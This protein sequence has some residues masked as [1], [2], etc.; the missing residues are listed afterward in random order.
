M[1]EACEDRTVPTPV[2]T[3]EVISHFNESG[4]TGQVRFTRD[5]TTG[6]LAV[7][8]SVGGTATAGT[9]HTLMFS[10]VFFMPG[11]ATADLWIGA[12][13]DS[14]SEPTETVIVTVTSGT[15]YTIGSSASATVNLYDDD[16]QYVSVAKVNDA[17]EGGAS[18]TVRFTRIGDLSS[19]LTANFTVGGTATSGTD[20]TSIGTTVTFSANSATADK[21]V[22]PL[23][24]NLIETTDETVVVTATSGSGYTVQSPTAATVTIED[25][26][27]TVELAHLTDGVEGVSNGSVRF[28]RSG[29]DLTAALT[30]EYLASGT[31]TSGTDYTALSGTLTFAANS[32]TADLTV[33]V[34]NDSDTEYDEGVVIWTDTADGTT[35]VPGAVY[36][37]LVL[38]ADT[39]TPLV[40]VEA[41]ADGLEGVYDGQL[42]FTRKGD[43]R[44]A[45]T[46]DIAVSGTATSGTD[47]TAIGT[48][49]TFAA[50]AADA[51]VDVEALTDGSYDPD[52]TVIVTIQTGTGYTRDTVYAATLSIE[53]AIALVNVAKIEDAWEDGRDGR[54]LFTRTGDL[55]ATLTVNYT[56]GGTATSGT[57]FISVGTSVTFAAGEAEAV[58]DVEP[59]ADATSD[60][61]E[62][63][64]VTISTS[65]AYQ[66]GTSNVAALMIVDDDSQLVTVTKIAD[67]F[68]GGANGTLRFTRTGD[69][70]ASLTV[71]YTVT[72]TA[73]GGTD[74]TALSGS[75]SFAANVTSADV[76]VALL[77]D[78]SAESTET[79][80]V[81]VTSGSAYGADPHA[82]D[83][84][85]V[86]DDDTNTGVI[87]GSVWFDADADGI[88]DSG[89]DEAEGYSVTLRDENGGYIADTLTNSSGVY[90]FPGLPEG[91][92]FV[93][94]R[95]QMGWNTTAPDQG[96]NDSID[97]DVNDNG[98]S[99][100]ISL[101]SG[102]M[103]KTNVGARLMTIAAPDVADE[104][105]IITTV[106]NAV[107]GANGDLKVAKW[108]GS[109]GGAWASV[110]QP[111]PG[112][113]TVPKLPGVNANGADFIDLDDDRFN[114][115]VKDAGAWIANTPF[116]EVTLKTLHADGLTT[117][118]D[119]TTISLTRMTV[120]GW[121]GWY[122][123]DS[124][125]LVSTEA[126]DKH[127]D[128]N[129]R[130]DD[131]GPVW[132]AGFNKKA[133]HVFEVSDRTHRISIGGKVS[134]VYA[135]QPAVTATVPIEKTIKLHITILRNKSLVTGGTPLIDPAQVNYDVAIMREI[136]AQAGIRVLMVDDNGATIDAVGGAQVKDPPADPNLNLLNGILDEFTQLSKDLIFGEKIIMTAEEV[137]L[138]GHAPYR[139][140]TVGGKD[141]IEVYYVKTLSNRSDGEAFTASLV[142]D[143]KYK[144]SLILNAIHG[145]TT[146]A[147]E[148]MHVLID[149]GSHPGGKTPTAVQRTNL[150]VDGDFT[151]E[152]NYL[153]ID[154]RRLTPAQS[155]ALR[156]TVAE[157]V[158]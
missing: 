50:G 8:F 27:A 77:T 124:Q 24:D 52:E 131:A 4:S 125:I 144:H 135:G 106:N 128:A 154:S 105:V 147:H 72:G 99:N 97:S 83:V 57:D 41:T 30:I 122:W 78:T 51:V 95:P 33:T 66:V 104:T 23:A 43:L 101:L 112:A 75:V 116:I 86:I 56:V 54:L 151:I 98:W 44:S 32:A 14:T 113:P 84:V 64:S 107:L 158:E 69:T 42:W 94:I 138:L 16:A 10:G 36:E 19:R 118:D 127:R 79:V 15:G 152:K 13:Q 49:V 96:G 67:A 12:Y 7:N 130:A 22:A 11:M 133:G 142:P 31:A 40:T 87:G 26:P 18:G 38:I 6:S 48:T 74:Y 46:I 20:Y 132:W 126:D 34:L 88:Q 70:T 9:D 91:D 114:I 39:E 108:G 137:A 93:H 139:T 100:A 60:P 28:T 156:G 143:A 146:L 140:Q 117:N 155:I 35:Y 111:T 145:Y 59:L 63:V 2:V 17:V 1:L 25:D 123:S 71:S 37:A 89:E 148:A 45:L 82:V 110:F 92:Y 47:F 150:L 149:D 134:V 119:A 81:T 129:V 55:T 65:S 153:I 141:D 80:I 5:D 157:L 73:V 85:N 120:P 58:V 90:A 61:A 109:S 121:A 103:T 102:A 76:S 21:T 53:D 3:A 136:Y 68:E 62:T 29:G 115:R